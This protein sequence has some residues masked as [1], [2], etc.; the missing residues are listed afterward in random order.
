MNGYILQNIDGTPQDAQY[1][2]QNRVHSNNAQTIMHNNVQSHNNS[3]QLDGNWT[4]PGG[5]SCD[6][7]IIMNSEP[8]FFS[9]AIQQDVYQG[10]GIVY[11]ELYSFKGKFFT[12]RNYHSFKTGRWERHLAINYTSSKI[13]IITFSYVLA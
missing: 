4:I 3:E 13:Y 5:R 8:T 2:A 11:L 9:T 12:F 1:S 7:N 6:N 10:L